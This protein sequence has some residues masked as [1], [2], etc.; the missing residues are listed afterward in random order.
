NTWWHPYYRRGELHT[1]QSVTKTIT[2]VVVGTARARHEFP[3]LDTPVLKFFDEAKVANLD[4]R[5]RQMTIRHLL[6]MTAGLEW[7]EDLPYEDPK[8]S[9]GIMEATLDWVKYTIDRPMAQEPG[10]LFNYNSGATQLLAHV[11]RAAT[12]KA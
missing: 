4:D 3:D 1:L 11:F 8:N 6:T 10:S 5:K 7:N 2:S 12:G 9:A